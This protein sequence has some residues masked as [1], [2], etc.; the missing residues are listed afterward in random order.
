MTL[1]VIASFWTGGPLSLIEQTVIRSYVDHG[2]HFVLFTEGDVQG[3]PEGIEHCNAAEIWNDP[4]IDLSTASRQVIATYS[5]IFRL[6]L[7]SQTEMIWVDCDAYCVR[8]F[9]YESPQIFGMGGNGRVCTGVLRLAAEDALLHDMLD[10]VGSTCPIQAWRNPDFLKRRA[11]MRDSGKVWTI[12]DL[13]WGCAGP[14]LLTWLLDRGNRLDDAL[15][16]PVLYPLFGRNLRKLWL[17]DVPIREIEPE[18]CHSVHIF[19]ASREILIK[20]HDGI[21][22]ANSYLERIA[23][24]HGTLANSL[25]NTG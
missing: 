10:F 6:H 12:F 3:I 19:G 25:R 8:P 15:P 14:K 23:L 4:S 24:R 7:L 5:D 21:P 9:T 1:P 2:H 18:G 13:P 22:P 11:K 16:Q 17:P 20:N